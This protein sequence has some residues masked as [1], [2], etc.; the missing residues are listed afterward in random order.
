MSSMGKKDE[1]ITLKEAAQITGY[2]PDY[3]GQLIRAGKLEGKQVYSNVAWMTTREALEEYQANK[4]KKGEPTPWE[5]L[6]KLLSSP[7][8]L[9]NMYA[10]VA[11]VFI[12]T[13]VGII[14]C[15]AYVFAVSLDSRISARNLEKA[16]QKAYVE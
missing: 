6:E 2:T 9:V 12:A 7:E 3:I 16:Q 1:F 10:W 4:D 15:I 5:R 11:W 13:L 14:I 8:T